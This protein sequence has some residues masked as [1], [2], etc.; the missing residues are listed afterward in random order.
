[1]GSNPAGRAS[2]IKG[3]QIS[4][5]SPLSFVP[6]DLQALVVLSAIGTSFLMKGLFSYRRPQATGSGAKP[7]GI[8]Y[9]E[10]VGV[11]FPASPRIAADDSVMSCALPAR[12]RFDGGY[13]ALLFVMLTGCALAQSV[14]P[15]VGALPTSLE[16]PRLNPWLQPLLQCM[17]APAD[18]DLD[19]DMGFINTDY[20][21]AIDQGGVH[22][23][24]FTPQPTEEDAARL[25]LTLAG[26]CEQLASTRILVGASRNTAD[27]LRALVSKPGP[28]PV[29]RI[30]KTRRGWMNPATHAKV[31]QL[32]NGRDLYFTVHGSLNLQTV[33]MTCK[34]NNAMR[35]VETRP[36]LYS[37]FTQLASAV[38]AGSGQARFGDGMGSENGSGSDIGPVPIGNYMVQFYGGRAGEFVGGDLTSVSRDFPGNINPPIAGQYLPGLV[39][40]YDNVLFDAARQLRQG[41]DVRIDVMIFE[42]GQQNAFVLN[43][44]KFVQ[45]GF[46]AGLTEDKRSGERVASPF[47]GKL[48]VRFLWQFQ[49]G[50]QSSGPTFAAL[51]GPDAIDSPGGEYLLEKATIWNPPHTGGGR[52]KPTTPYD[53]HNKVMLLD[54]VGHEQ[55]RRIYV[56]SS[57]LDQPG[58]GSGRL[59]QAGTVISAGAGPDAWS[60][61]TRDAP[62]LWNAY[63]RYFGMLWENRDG[64]PGSGQVAFYARIA[65][66]HSRGAV[67]WIETADPRGGAQREGIDAY[68]YPMPLQM[69]PDAQGAAAPQAGLAAGGGAR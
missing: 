34:A 15:P 62:S 13:H 53:M 38:A 57:N 68:F 39:N 21:C 50:L 5:C 37:R 35:F 28:D 63:H 29:V 23:H 27:E 14:D 16:D 66:E 42:V 44:W 64:Q 8:P 12:R 19:L 52:Y 4:V 69:T 31:F 33:G 1:M 2:I 24:T 47:P 43:L 11:P 55:E 45:Q 59:W 56:T 18:Y 58:V 30:G 17:R 67:N 40:W 41:R 22:F 51:H 20:A 10:S 36:A 65:R 49:S 3:L 54:V 61:A 48:H 32:G 25:T 7:V 60:N 9:D 46:G 6:A 26:Q